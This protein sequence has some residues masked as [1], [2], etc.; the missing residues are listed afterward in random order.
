[1]IYCRPFYQI[2]FIEFHF[3]SSFFWIFY[4]HRWLL[5]KQNKML[6]SRKL[7][8]WCST[9]RIKTLW[10]MTSC[11][12]FCHGFF[13][14]NIIFTCFLLSVSVALINLL[15]F[16]F[17]LKQHKNNCIFTCSGISNENIFPVF[18]LFTAVK[19]NWIWLPKLVQRTLLDDAIYSNVFFCSRAFISIFA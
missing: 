5:Y 3:L 13:Y 4:H 8:V 6:L 19:E 11:T 7:L 16:F 18:L 15:F 10:D 12:C 14:Y 17:T 1:M 9:K 2:L